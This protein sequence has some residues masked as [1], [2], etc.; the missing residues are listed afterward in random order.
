MVSLY[1]RENLDMYDHVEF[2]RVKNEICSDLKAEE[3][4]NM[5]IL[6][7]EMISN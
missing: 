6:F 3:F 2:G 4:L 1:K 7:R 5:Y